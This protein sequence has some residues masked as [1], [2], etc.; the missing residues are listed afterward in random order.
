M[1]RKDSTEPLGGEEHL[2]HSEEAH[3]EDLPAGHHAP[4]KGLGHRKFEFIS[5]VA[6]VLGFIAFAV[7]VKY[8]T[9]GMADL[10]ALQDRVNSMATA[11]NETQSRSDENLKQLNYKLEEVHTFPSRGL[12]SNIT[13]LEENPK[14]IRSEEVDLALKKLERLKASLAGVE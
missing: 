8:M 5:G 9:S 2:A 14:Y 4:R 3:C 13:F 1:S 7:C 6:F 12:L 10:S 11:Q